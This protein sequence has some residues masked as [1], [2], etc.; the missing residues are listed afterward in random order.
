M[1]HL[2]LFNQ[3]SEYEAY[4]GG[5]DVVLPNVSYVKDGK[6]YYNPAESGLV[7]KMVDLGLPSGTLW[8][9]RN[10]GATSPEDAGLYFAWGDTVGYTVEQVANGEH[11]FNE[12]TYWDGKYP[13]T[14]YQ[15]IN[16]CV[17]VPENDAATL[18]MG[19]QYEMP[20]YY[21]FSEL[22][23]NTTVLVVDNDGF[24][25]DVKEAM[26]N[27]D[28]NNENWFKDFV[29]S[30]PYV[31][32]L[33]KNGNS[34]KFKLIDGYCN[35]WQSHTGAVSGAPGGA[36]YSDLGWGGVGF[37]TTSRYLNNFVRGVCK[38][39]VDLKTHYIQTKDD[40]EALYKFIAL[41]MCWGNLDTPFYVANFTEG[42]DENWVTVNY[43]SALTYYGNYAYFSGTTADGKEAYGEINPDNY[44]LSFS[45]YD[46]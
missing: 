9:D 19:K 27:T 40:I 12:E 28:Q 10:V 15:T 7:Y 3:A 4:M 42:E 34:V 24:E 11:V 6:V 20:S 38:Q 37:G 46:A 41:G 45:I 35:L 5:G 17:L 30:Y 23:K 32:Y 21:D 1:K 16:D 18:Y 2:K 33:G 8:A 22:Y 26:D 43:I 36:S 14:K 44:T 31:K 25:F 39:H 29:T 13:Y